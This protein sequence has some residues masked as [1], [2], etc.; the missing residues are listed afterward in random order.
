MLAFVPISTER[1]TV[2]A[3]HPLCNWVPTITSIAVSFCDGIAV[4][5]NGGI[6]EKSIISVVV[7]PVVAAAMVRAMCI[8][9]LH[10][11]YGMVRNYYK[12]KKDKDDERSENPNN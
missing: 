12:V 10:T 11:T 1:S 3:F 5:D 6:G 7:P 8:N 4:V 9:T 2:N